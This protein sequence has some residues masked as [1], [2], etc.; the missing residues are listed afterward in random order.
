L[1]L[2]RYRWRTDERNALNGLLAEISC[3]QA[4][5]FI[6]RA[7]NCDKYVAYIDAGSFLCENLTASEGIL[8]KTKTAGRTIKRGGAGK[9]FGKAISP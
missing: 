4:F 6:G 9:Q 8:I 7:G 2:A 3:R 1:K 5:L